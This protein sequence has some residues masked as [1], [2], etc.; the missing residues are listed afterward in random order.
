M[1]RLLTID[2]AANELGVPAGSLRRAAERHG[3]L[4][5]MGRAIRIDADTLGELIEKCRENPQAHG[6]T[7]TLNGSSSTSATAADSSAR[8]LEIAEK[9]K[10][11][12]PALSSKR[13][14]QPA[15]VH[16]IK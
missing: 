1:P 6:C 14:G 15:Q 5:R 9:L 10:R 13:T 4:V 3:F 11:R 7:S 16:P 12:S 2:E 8:A